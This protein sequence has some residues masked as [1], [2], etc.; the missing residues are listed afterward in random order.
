MAVSLFESSATQALLD[1]WGDY[2]SD[3]AD[4]VDCGRPLDDDEPI[5][6]AFCRDCRPGIEYPPVGVRRR[7]KEVPR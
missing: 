3:L 7:Y 6:G 4:C 2:A 5:L 1:G